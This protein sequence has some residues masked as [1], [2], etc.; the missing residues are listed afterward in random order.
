MNE[1]KTLK[2]I[3]GN[4]RYEY[5]QASYGCSCGS[6][7]E[8]CFGSCDVVKLKAEAV[9]W[10]KWHKSKPILNAGELEDW[11]IHF[12]NLTEED[13]KEKENKDERRY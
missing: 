10:V 5:K 11:I 8:G 9:K 1:L 6:C 4:D 12:F 13:L 3:F 7:S 2:E